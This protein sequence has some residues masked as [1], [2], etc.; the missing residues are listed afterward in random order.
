MS[1]KAHSLFSVCIQVIVIVFDDWTVQCYDS[2][3]RLLW[4][5]VLMDLHGRHGYVMND[6][7]I[8]ITPHVLNNGLS[9]TVIVGASFSHASHGYRFVLLFTCSWSCVRNKGF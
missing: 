8:L 5:Q 6:V 4:S 3:L 1:N 2:N 7:G 9:G